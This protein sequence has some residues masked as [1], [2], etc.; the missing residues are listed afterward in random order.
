MD[1]LGWQQC[2]G[3]EHPQS[4]NAAASYYSIFFKSQNHWRTNFKMRDDV[5]PGKGNTGTRWCIKTPRE[6]IVIF[7]L[8][9]AP[10]KSEA[11]LQAGG[12]QSKSHAP[13]GYVPKI[14]PCSYT[15]TCMVQ[16]RSI[17]L[18]AYHLPRWSW[19][20]STSQHFH[21]VY[22]GKS[23]GPNLKSLHIWVQTPN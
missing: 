14:E 3:R 6:K 4:N 20:N 13:K 1:P 12:V 7:C 10:C 21:A 2:L 17:S 16:Q 9:G 8:L 5:M 19:N 23:K 18:F 11:S 15:G 22:S